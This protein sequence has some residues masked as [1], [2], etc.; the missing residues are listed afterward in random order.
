MSHTYTVAGTYSVTEIVSGPDGPLTNTQPNC[1]TAR[2]PPPSARFTATPTEGV[3]PL[4]VT[5]T[6]T[7][8]G[9]PITVWY[10]NFGDSSSAIVTASGVSHMYTAAG[11]YAVTETVSGPGGSSTI[12][13]TPCVEV[14]SQA[15]GMA[16]Q[17]WQEEYFTCTNCPQAQMSAD[18]DGTGQNNLFKFMA[19][20]N[21]TNPASLFLLQI[22]TVPDQQSQQNLSFGPVASGRIYT[23][24]FA[25]DL[26]SGV[27]LPLTGYAGPVTNGN[28]IIITDLDAT[29]PSKFY[30]INISLLP[31]SIT[32][33]TLGGTY[34]KLVWCGQPGTNVVQVTSGSYSS[35]FRDL[36]T[37]IMPDFGATNYTDEGAATTTPSRF[38][39]ICFRPQARTFHDRASGIP[40]QPRRLIKTPLLLSAVL[41]SLAR[42]PV[43]W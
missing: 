5:F 42:R 36:A 2:P 24:E 41:D 10:W 31:F 43:R 11:N 1:I 16:Y 34:V 6:D 18:A 33:I 29:Q 27:W 7:S 14:L 25:A 15:Q 13:A 4:T 21:P 19:G 3:A 28:Q 9:G 8:T 38:Y 17:A 35:N 12:S 20:L 40:K 30:R 32:S 26:V 23:P 39:R 22:A 37:I